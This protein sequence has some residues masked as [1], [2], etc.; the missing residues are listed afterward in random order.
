VLIVAVFQQN[1]KKVNLPQ[2]VLIV[3]GMSVVV[4]KPSI[5]NHKTH[6]NTTE[7]FN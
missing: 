3:L 6:F 1:A 2:N 4:G 5:I 7:K